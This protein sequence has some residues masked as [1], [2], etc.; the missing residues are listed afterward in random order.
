MS[1]WTCGSC[2]AENVPGT[3]FCGYC[4]TQRG[5]AAAPEERRLIT[6]LFA[7][8]SGFTSLAEQLDAE[9]LLD[10]IDPIIGSLSEIVGRYEG[11][12]EKYA[13]DALLA[14]FGAPVAHDDDAERALRAALDMHVELS[15]ICAEFPPDRPALTLHVGVTSGHGIA[16]MLGSQ[17]RMDYAVLGDSVILAQRLESAAPA[18]ETYVGE[19]TVQLTRH[20]FELES[21]GELTLK[22]KSEPVPAWR[23]VGERERVAA[24][25]TRLVGRARELAVVDEVL[26]HGGVLTLTGEPGV[27]KSRIAVEARVRAEARGIRWLQGRCVSY[28]AALA[29]WP[30][31]DLLREV[32][33]PERPASP[34]VDRLLGLS[35]DVEVEP[36]GYRRAL[37]GDVV[38][39][40]AGARREP[41]DRRRRSRTCTGQTSRRSRSPPSW[42]SW[43]RETRLVLF[44]VARPEAGPRLEDVAGAA[45]TLALEP[46]GPS[47]VAELLCDL[48]PEVPPGLAETVHERT[49]GNA[50]F[51]GELAR[52]L[53]EQ[54]TAPEELPPTIEG[55]L[56]A[57]IDSLPQPAVALLQTASVIG[58]RVPL[59]LLERVA[60]DV[61]GLEPA[62][63]QLVAAGFLDRNGADERLTFHHALMQDAAY[64]RLLRRTRRDLHR[65]VADEAE[66]LYGAGDD[67]VELLARHLYLGEAGPKA[68]EYLVRAA[69]RAKGLFANDEAIV[70]FE[71]ALELSGS[72][73]AIALALAE[74]R[75]LMG[76]YDQALRLYSEV[77]SGNGDLRAWRG[78]AA[79]LRKQGRY[80]E[81]L[82]LLDGCTG[83]RRVAARARLDAVGRRPARGSRRR[84]RGRAGGRREPGRR[85]HRPAPAP[86]RTGGDARRPPGLGARPRARRRADLHERAGPPRGRRRAA[87]PG[88]RLRGGRPAGRGRVGVAARPDDRR[89]RRRR[90]GDR[91]LPAQPR[92]GRARARQRRRRG[93]ARPARDLGVR[94]HRPRLGAGGRQREPGGEAAGCRGAGRGAEPV[95]NRAPRSR[96]RSA[97]RR[98]S[99][100]SS[101]R[102]LESCCGRSASPRR[103]SGPSSRRRRSARWGPT[104][105]RRRPP[106]SRNRPAGDGS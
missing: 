103:S 65:R 36:E 38:P 2:A 7:D 58:R 70:H 26:E 35:A 43:Q 53:D 99:R 93:R 48:L 76:E 80:D 87:D 62:I 85:C 69:Q 33:E 94:A 31:A 89:A 95:R 24:S 71:R 100:T 30:Y 47:D 40:A 19:T 45:R 98:P 102:R 34:Y 55:V 75:D 72:D 32:P 67:A 37:H 77:R 86:T 21:V 29:Y 28:G 88:E 66:A 104:R 64:G 83:R 20:R 1:G 78:A 9:Q 92:H 23:L 12:V 27:G 4:G 101:E 3:R 17:A 105:R 51:V 96:K 81:A 18:G 41:A 60:T 61:D 82:A 11:H 16:R 8:L 73:P 49:E 42:P 22:G 10:V 74:L 84:A 90:R 57:R 25:A 52:A 56:A 44:L 6:S 46:L 59:P 50:F 63:D 14:L 91:R 97:I 79:A 13:G 54:G 106:S 39:L 68:I 5:V 15:R